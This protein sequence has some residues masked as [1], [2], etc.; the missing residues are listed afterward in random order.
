MCGIFGGLG[1]SVEESKNAID[2]I[3]RGEE[4]TNFC[5]YFML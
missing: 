1:I 2:L 5:L 4:W 3:K